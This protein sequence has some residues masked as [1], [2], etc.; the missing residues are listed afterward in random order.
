MS[1]VQGHVHP[2][3]RSAA[4]NSNTLSNWYPTRVNSWLEERERKLVAMRA[5]DLV[6]ND[7][8][9]AGLID[10]ISINTVGTGLNPQ[11]RVD[12]KR[13]GLSDDEAAAFQ[14][15][16]EKAWKD[17]CREADA[18]ERMHFCDIQ[19]LNIRSML[20]QGEFINLPLMLKKP[21]RKFSLAL[22]DV[23]PARM[24]T[25]M[26]MAASKNVRGGV[27][28]GS[29]REPLGYYLANPASGILSSFL[30]S[31]QFEYIKAWRGHRPQVLHRFFV[32][33]NEQVRG[34]SILAP[35]MK[36][37]RDL[38]DYLDFELVANIIT[39]SF[40]VFIETS[41]PT[42]MGVGM[43]DETSEET[44]ERYQSYS[45]GQVLYG[46]MNQKP[47]LLSSNRPGNTFPVF[48]ERI[49]RAAGA[50]T[51]MPY[52]IISKDFSK[53]NYSSARAALL[54]A[55]RCFKLYR[56]WL[57]NHFCQVVWEMVLEEA[58]L[59]GLLDLPAS[60][61]DFYDARAEYCQAEWIGPARG[62]V[63]PVKEMTADIAGIEAG[64]MTMADVVA[65]RGGD[66][67][68]VVAQRAR[69][70]DVLEAAGLSGGTEQAAGRLASI[71]P[72]PEEEKPGEPS[73]PGEEDP[74]ESA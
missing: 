74:V 53:T 36:F 32:R 64:I 8:H 26:D 10:S 34:E 56:Q 62:Y 42:A 41:D 21:G 49:L 9:A 7:G 51:G 44:G 3:S 58:W 16:A 35:A 39:A 45:P 24:A 31:S 59:L 52:E 1:G 60:A 61:P 57:R 63:D 25:P 37:F 50:A 66:W 19:Y 28:L 67:E 20:V 29:C 55:W 48:V 65:E 40:P 43:G 70:R 38:A 6:A 72:D 12:A 30:D 22:H 13:L 69:E 17:W 14:A 23:H 33:E 68:Q 2:V 11:S 5:E 27:H 18:G 46:G 15:S 71:P 54:E 4:G 47:H 73:G